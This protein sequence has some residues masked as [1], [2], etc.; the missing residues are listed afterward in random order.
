MRKREKPIQQKKVKNS[1]T[2]A[3]VTTSGPPLPSS[4][5]QESEN[6]IEPLLPSS[7]ELSEEAAGTTTS[8]HEIQPTGPV[9]DDVDDLMNLA[10]SSALLENKIKLSLK[11]T[12]PMSDDLELIEEEH[13][14]NPHHYYHRLNQQQQ[15]QLIH[16]TI[17]PSHRQPIITKIN[18]LTGE[19][20]IDELENEIQQTISTA[21]D[22]CSQT[23]L[24]LNTKDKDHHA[25]KSS[26]AAREAREAREAKELKKKKKRYPPPPLPLPPQR[27][28]QSQSHHSPRHHHREESSSAASSSSLASLEQLKDKHSFYLQKIIQQQ[29]HSLDLLTQTKSTILNLSGGDPSLSSAS[30]PSSSSSHPPPLTTRIN[31]DP[32]PS[33]SSSSSSPPKIK[34]CAHCDLVTAHHHHPPE[35]HQQSPYRYHEQFDTL[36]AHAP[37]PPELSSPEPNW[38]PNPSDAEKVKTQ[39]SAE[40]LPKVPIGINEKQL[41]RI[42]KERNIRLN[43]YDPS[44]GLFGFDK[45]QH[46]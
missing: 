8:G 7:M 37:L 28:Q 16:Y 24:T 10:K 45:L 29:K 2:V 3:T 43:T 15:P 27:Q 42:A 19:G 23:L 12:N 31:L 41:L 4:S 39:L 1:R 30:A 5:G 36:S 14:M 18:L 21:L 34:S 20:M 25:F 38:H 11:N 9:Y 22:V 44:S 33:S 17:D 46:R 32:M 35:S 40:P 6:K 13:E 26:K